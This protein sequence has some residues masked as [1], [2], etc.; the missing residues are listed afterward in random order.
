MFDEL[1]ILYPSRIYPE[2]SGGYLRTFNIARL[3]SEKFSKTYIL[4]MDEN[5]EYNGE[6]D[7]IHLIQGKK[8]SNVIDKIDYYSR[9]IFSRNFSFKS[10]D[11][12]FYNTNNVLF[13]I[14]DPLF[15]NL[16]KKKGIKKYVLDEHNVYWKL[17]TFP[18]FNFK[19]RI[20][21]KLTFARNKSIEIKAIRNATHVL[22]CSKRDK[23]VILQEVPEVAN[24]I[25]VIPNCVD[26]NEYESYLRYEDM[27][28]R[29]KELFFVF[30]VGSFAYSP[31]ID[32]LHI[33]CNK[34]APSFGSE[35]KFIIVGGNPP[36]I[37]RSKNVKFLG[38]VEDVKR[39][40][41]ESDI[42]IAPLR[43]G[44]GTRLKILEYMAMGKPVISTAKGVEGIDCIPNKDV[45]IEDNTDAFSERIEELL[46][47]KRKRDDIGK[48][49][50]E[51]IK[52]KY[53]WKIYK[54]TLQSVYDAIGLNP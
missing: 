39:Y 26:F 36:D 8:Y 20:Y 21:N 1:H 51:L 52:Q 38:Y 41:L 22:V 53:D 34:I 45:I 10:P 47:D 49:A 27:K 6:V 14:E 28:D 19:Y 24:K 32:A 44:S 4:A 9:G 11:R 50:M 54:K 25:T 30:F 12:A 43:Y 33:I 23:R 48:N 7:G 31:N 18:T 46:V 29:E 40:L 37:T 15:Y 13:Q 2:K 5:I 42:C 16:L 3:V 17:L 35:V